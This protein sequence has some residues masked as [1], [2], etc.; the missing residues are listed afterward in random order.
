MEVSQ[1]LRCMFLS[2]FAERILENAV[3][4]F[5]AKKTFV[6]KFVIYTHYQ[7]LTKLTEHFH[8]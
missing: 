1:I 8:S 4:S 3:E 7:I 6:L 2:L 5:D